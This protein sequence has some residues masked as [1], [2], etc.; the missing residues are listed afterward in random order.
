MLLSP[1]LYIFDIDLRDFNDDK[2]NVLVEIKICWSCTLRWK[3]KSSGAMKI[4]E[5]WVNIKLTIFTP[6][7]TVFRLL[8]VSKL[9]RNAETGETELIRGQWVYIILDS[10]WGRRL[11]WPRI[12]PISPERRCMIK[13][14]E[15]VRFAS[16]ALHGTFAVIDQNRTS[17]IGG[18]V[19]TFNPTTNNENVIFTV[20]NYHHPKSVFTR[21][22]TV[23]FFLYSLVIT[24]STVCWTCEN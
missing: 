5:F 11:A 19:H 20:N 17:T 4:A 14:L 23:F 12:I 2:Q 8:K 13:A 22:R 3:K 16:F 1:I 18:K 10:R 6:N 21:L 9:K 24:R 7:V 15:N